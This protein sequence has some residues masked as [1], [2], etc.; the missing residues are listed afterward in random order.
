VITRID[1][2]GMTGVTVPGRSGR[3]DQTAT[4]YLVANHLWQGW[5]P[6]VKGQ[7]VIFAHEDGTQ[8]EVPRQVCVIYTAP[9][10]PAVEKGR[11][12]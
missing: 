4:N 12:A 11:A 6:A 3:R 9:D 1:F 8:I 2:V 7:A 5:T 10:A